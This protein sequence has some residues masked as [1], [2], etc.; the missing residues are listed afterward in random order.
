LYSLSE[1]LLVDDPIKRHSI[2]K[3]HGCGRRAN[4]QVERT[5]GESRGVSALHH[6]SDVKM[7]IY[8]PPLRRNAE[9]QN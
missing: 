2:G 8:Q 6:S 7:S 4:R 3:T 5:A 1:R 9:R